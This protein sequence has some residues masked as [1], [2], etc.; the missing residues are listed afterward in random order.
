[1]HH[2]V[3]LIAFLALCVPHV[4]PSDVCTCNHLTCDTPT[5]CSHGLVLDQCGC[6]IVCARRLGEPCGGADNPGVCGRGLQCVVKAKPGDRVTGMEQGVCQEL[7]PNCDASSCDSVVTHKCPSDSVLV[8]N[9]TKENN[10]CCKTAYE[11]RCDMTLCKAPR[12]AAGHTPLILRHSNQRPGSCCDLY[13]CK[14]SGCWSDKG[15]VYKDGEA[16]KEGDCVTCLCVGGKRQCQAEMCMKTCLSPKYVPGR[17][18]PIC[19]SPSSLYPNQSSSKCPSLST[20]NITC[21]TG[22]QKTPDGCHVCKC[23]PE[24][25]WKDC[26]YGYIHSELGEETCECQ[27]SPSECPALDSCSKHCNHGY[28]LSKKGCPKCRCNKCASFFCDKQCLLGHQKDRNG[29]KVCKCQESLWEK[30]CTMNMTEYTPGQS[31]L[32]DNCNVCICKRDGQVVCEPR[33]CPQLSCTFMVKKEGECCPVCLNISISNVFEEESSNRK[34]E[35]VEEH[36]DS[37]D[38]QEVDLRD[39]EEKYII[40]LSIVGTLVMLLLILVFVLLY[41]KLK[42]R[43][44]AS[45]SVAGQDTYCKCPLFI[46]HS[47]TLQHKYN[48]ANGNI[49]SKLTYDTVVVQKYAHPCVEVS[50]QSSESPDEERRLFIAESEKMKD[51]DAEQTCDND[52]Q[53]NSNFSKDWAAV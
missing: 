41:L 3:K 17:C 28:K 44:Q 13:H 29:C 21:Q 9:S 22:L 12:C 2:L 40:S 24:N 11:C 45:W 51:F 48:I 31:W 7:A 34:L 27:K 16:W 49:P 14:V 52:N 10:P 8:Y 6:C 36:D 35:P 46:G 38:L 4:T 1:M 23:K 37:A 19:D 20:C 39:M 32:D 42:Q 25:C 15:K 26:P 47:P 43:H 18:C 5:N 50:V 30:N 53:N 33:T